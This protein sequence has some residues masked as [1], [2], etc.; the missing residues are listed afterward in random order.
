MIKVTE[1]AEQILVWL[2]S[3]SCHVS[4]NKGVCSSMKSNPKH[5]NGILKKPKP[6][7]LETE[8]D[9]ILR[10]LELSPRAAQSADSLVRFQNKHEKQCKSIIESNSMKYDQEK[11]PAGEKE[12]YSYIH[13]KYPFIRSNR[14]P[15]MVEGL[16]Q[17]H[18][19]PNRTQ[20]DCICLTVCPDKS[21]EL[22]AFPLWELVETT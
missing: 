17:Y 9:V 22:V 20:A 18:I 6:R 16:L 5:P 14:N 10:Q 11:L 4:F 13:P 21:I 12:Y 7:W 19:F 2:D 15:Q 8:L 1:E 3:S